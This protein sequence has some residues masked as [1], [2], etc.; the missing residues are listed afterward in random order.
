MSDELALVVP[1]IDGDIEGVFDGTVLVLVEALTEL[2]E[3]VTAPG[4]AGSSGREAVLELVD[5]IG[6]HKLLGAPEYCKRSVNVS[7]LVGMGTSFIGLDSGVVLELDVGNDD[8][9][10]TVGVVE[11]IVSLGF[12]VDILVAVSVTV[13]GVGLNVDGTRSSTVVAMLL[14]LGAESD[15]V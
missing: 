1:I 8:S 7:A 6:V 12:V 2:T 10:A 4:K 13:S 15:I 9:E 14:V 5:G 3:L 11:A